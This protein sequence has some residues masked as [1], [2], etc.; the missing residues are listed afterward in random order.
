MTTTRAPARLR[1]GHELPELAEPPGAPP[2][3]HRRGADHDP[4]LDPLASGNYGRVTWHGDPAR[5]PVQTR[6]EVT[7]PLPMIGYAT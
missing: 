4:E 6:R 5:W 3:P 1:T 7:V 2:H